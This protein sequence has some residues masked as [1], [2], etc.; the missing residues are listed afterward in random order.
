MHK[1]TKNLVDTYSGF[2]V[3]TLN[4]RGM[5]K[6]RVGK[7]LADAALGE[8]I[9]ILHYKVEWAGRQWLTLS[10]FTRSTGICPDCGTVGP[11]LP[12]AVREWACSVCGAVHD[13]DV[14]AAQ[15]V[16][17]KCQSQRLGLQQSSANSAGASQPIQVGQALSEPVREDEKRGIAVG[18]GI[19][20]TEGVRYYG[21][22]TN[23]LMAG[24]CAGR[25]P[26]SKG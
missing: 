20:S 7:S 10:A 19:S 2:A 23:V 21:P 17:A 13:R 6:S 22:P 1:A 3:E 4:I 11:K 15:V 18:I 16:L 5:M 8:F 14:A 24:D 25:V 12:L 9:R 26:L